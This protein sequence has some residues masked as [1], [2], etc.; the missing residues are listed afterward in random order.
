MPVISNAQVLA[1]TRGLYRDY[2]VPTNSVRFTPIPRAT[3]LAG[4]GINLT[5]NQ[6]PY[7]GDP[8]NQ[9]FT[10]E[11]IATQTNVFSDIP[12]YSTNLTLQEAPASTS[13]VLGAPGFTN[14]TNN[15]LNFASANIKEF[16]DRVKNGYCNLSIVG[17]SLWRPSN[18][19]LYSALFAALNPT[20]WR[21]IVT[22]AIAASAASPHDVYR[23]YESHG[24]NNFT[25]GTLGSLIPPSVPFPTY[26]LSSHTITGNV[27]AFPLNYSTNAT[28]LLYQGTTLGRFTAL[29]KFNFTAT[30]TDT[31]RSVYIGPNTATLSGT[32]G[33]GGLLWRGVLKDTSTYFDTSANGKFLHTADT[34]N[35]INP[36]TR[37]STSPVSNAISCKVLITAPT[38]EESL[39]N[40]HYVIH[41]GTLATGQVQGAWGGYLVPYDIHQGNYGTNVLTKVV[42]YQAFD[43]YSINVVDLG[44][45]SETSTS[46]DVA[47]PFSWFVFVD[48]PNETTSLTNNAG[49]RHKIVSVPVFRFY[50]TAMTTGLQI[51]TDGNS[52]YSARQVSGS[53]AVVTSYYSVTNLTS[54]VN[55]NISEYALAK[56]FEFEGTN[57]V[58]I[59]LGTNDLGSSA[60]DLFNWL[61]SIYNKVTSAWNTA[62]LN[63]PECG[64]NGE[65]L[66]NFVIPNTSSSDTNTANTN[67]SMLNSLKTLLKTFIAENPN[68]SYVDFNEILNRSFITG[69]TFAVGAG[70]SSTAAQGWD[71]DITGTTNYFFNRDNANVHPRGFYTPK[72]AGPSYTPA[73]DTEAPAYLLLKGFWTILNEAS[74]NNNFTS[75]GYLRPI[76]TSGGSLTNS[77]TTISAVSYQRVT[78]VDYNYHVTGLGILKKLK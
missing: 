54:G 14:T 8:G 75:L 49:D 43:D 12:T 27:S 72:D 64:N 37:R 65:L 78:E 48:G 22:S 41:N 58:M 73:L 10:V 55:G 44:R 28:R 69:G 36:F 1:I 25:W 16:A 2:R 62:K 42:N 15:T 17:D 40:V 38:K 6:L 30:I 45:V 76:N 4:G 9:V 7:T 29:K 60:A 34:L 31:G 39:G 20:N 46:V 5:N 71:L 24:Q 3:L 67:N 33:L 50:N 63:N 77:T 26:G 47:N 52:G 59:A 53:G 35:T 19:Y 61:R 32:G 56:R 51:G 74:A 70:Y 18:E 13:F 11:D 23:M 21:G 66:V 68:C 57:T